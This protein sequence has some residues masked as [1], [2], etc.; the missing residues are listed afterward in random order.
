MKYFIYFY[1]LWLFLLPLNLTAQN[2]T[3]RETGY[4]A[5]A[6]GVSSPRPFVALHNSPVGTLILI[7]N[8]ENNKTLVVEVVGSLP[9]DASEGVIIQLTQVVFNRL[10]AGDNTQMEVELSYMDREG[11]NQNPPQPSNVRTRYRSPIDSL[12]KIANVFE[13]GLAISFKDLKNPNELTALHKTAPIG[14]LILVKSVPQ[15]KPSKKII[16]KVIGKLPDNQVD[17][18]TIIQLSEKAFK[19]LSQETKPLPV[20]LEYYE[21]E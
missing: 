4:A 19:T 5:L 12:A 14:T 13:Q 15:N 20:K 1:I 6:E 18:D 11:N 8:T 7:S 17:K 21:K 10:G 9:S 16:V 3:F 2:E